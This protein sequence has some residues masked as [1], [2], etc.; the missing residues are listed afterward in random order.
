MNARYIHS[1]PGVYSLRAFAKERLPEAE[2]E[3][4][5]YTINHQ[6]DMVLQ[7]IYRKKPDFVGFSCYIWN[8]SQVYELARDLKQVLPETEIWLGGPEVSYDG[9]K[10]LS[11][12][13]EIRGIMSGEG[14]LTFSQVAE[15]YLAAED[16]GDGLLERLAEIRGITYR[17]SAGAVCENG[18]QRL[19][20]MDEIPFY[21]KD[22]AGFENRIVYY[23]SSRG[24]PFSCSYCLSSIDKSVRFRSLSLVKKELDFFLDRKVPQV[25]FVDRTFN[26]RREHTLGIW[27]HILDHDNGVTNFHFEV[28]ADLFD[29]EE[30]EMIGRMRPGLIQLEIGVQST[31]P[32]TI[33]EIR[34]KMDLT[35][36]EAA[37][38]RVHGYR[39]THQHLDLIAGLPWEDLGSFFRS[40]DQVYR[41]KPDQLQLGFLKV[42]KG[43]YMASQAGAYG[44]R[45][46][47]TPPYEVLST[48]WLSYGDVIRLKAMEEMVE[49]YYNS[50]QFFRTLSL[51]EKEYASPSQMFLDLAAYYEDHGFSGQS[52][53][54]MARYELLYGFIREREEKKRESVRNGETASGREEPEPPDCL[55][56]FRD[57]LMED[58]YLRENI[59]SRPSFA[60]DQTP[61]KDRIREFFQ[62]EEQERR[63]LPAYKDYDSRQMANMAHLE[64]MEDGSFLLFDYKERDPLWKNA[65]VLRFRYEKICADTERGTYEGIEESQSRA[66]GRHPGAAGRGVWHRVPLLP[67]S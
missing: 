63:W 1:N 2:I 51:L 25:K 13:P 11:Q 26:C 34:R 32:D 47:M 28:S 43:S 59:K 24:C 48:R 27:K 16:T 29:E 19:L 9:E 31:N 62:A 61:F 49:V 21:Y 22:M 64:A 67:G 10:I 41:M 15:A 44:L 12:E 40:F 14:E 18:P 8:I 5:E 6:V 3:I 54:R 33:R 65:R 55:P 38:D 39:N 36:L 57:R 35:K 45:Y 42:L 66:G 23:E 46:R 37:V 4:A 56:A 30:L 7:D 17:D 50:G 60:M 52:H 53:S 20:S 58:L